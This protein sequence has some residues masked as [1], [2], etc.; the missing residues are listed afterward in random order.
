SP[1]DGDLPGGSL[2]RPAVGHRRYLRG[3]R[4]ENGGVPVSGVRGEL[5]PQTRPYRQDALG[6]ADGGRGGV[7][8]A[9]ATR[10]GS[11]I[12][13]RRTPGGRTGPPHRPRP[14]EG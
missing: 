5:L 1:S 14:G 11:S 8:G 6:W 2:G 10:G 7:E 3:N 4:G 13:V 12:G 9:G